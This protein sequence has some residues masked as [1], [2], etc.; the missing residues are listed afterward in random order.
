MAAPGS[1]A[2]ATLSKFDTVPYSP[3]LPP[4]KLSNLTPSPTLGLTSRVLQRHTY[5]T[6]SEVAYH[7]R[8]LGFEMPVNPFASWNA[9][10][11]RM[12]YRTAR[13]MAGSDDVLFRKFAAR[14]LAAAGFSLP[15]WLAGSSTA[16][17]AVGTTAVGATVA[18]T[19]TAS[20][21]GATAAAGTAT[22]AFPVLAVVAG[23]GTVAIAGVL[24]WRWL[25]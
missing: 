14:G 10:T 1:L 2:P 18:S 25:R 24:L 23:V 4:A 12:I 6:G 22:V 5:A 19:T 8:K 15:A 21:V 17:A 16:G 11:A 9:S 13:R 20:V 3:S 7:P